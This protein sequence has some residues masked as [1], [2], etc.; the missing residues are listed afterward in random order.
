[1]KLNENSIYEFLKNRETQEREFFDIFEVGLVTY[2][3]QFINGHYSE[4]KVT[5]F[6]VFCR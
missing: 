4:C 5:Y 1:M 2:V 6:R 3:A